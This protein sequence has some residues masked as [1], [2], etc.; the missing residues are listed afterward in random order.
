[1]SGSDGKKGF[2]TKRG[3]F[4]ESRGIGDKDLT[5]SSTHCGHLECHLTA[6]SFCR[7]FHSDEEGIAALSHGEEELLCI[8]EGELLPNETVGSEVF[9]QSLRWTPQKYRVKSLFQITAPHGKLLV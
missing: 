6:C 8:D 7:S 1:M 9:P 4:K 5:V 3:E 2:E